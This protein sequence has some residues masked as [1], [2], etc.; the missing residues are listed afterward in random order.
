VIYSA[1]GE[2]AN[3]QLSL[4]AINGGGSAETSGTSR[5]IS[6]GRGVAYVSF[7]GNVD[8]L[9][10]VQFSQWSYNYNNDPAFMYN[11]AVFDGAQIQIVPEP[12]TAG[13]LITGIALAVALESICRRNARRLE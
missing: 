5:R 13:L 3:S 11:N 2:G 12:S 8:A 10:Q 4:A 7:T 6:D 9:G 1:G